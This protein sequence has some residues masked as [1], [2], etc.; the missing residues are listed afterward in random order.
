MMGFESYGFFVLKLVSI[1]VAI[2]MV[3]LGLMLISTRAKKVL[4]KGYLS[5]SSMDEAF[6]KQCQIVESQVF[7]KKALKQRAK[8]RKKKH[9][10]SQKNDKHKI[11]VLDFKGDIAASAVDN[12]R[13][14][15]DAVLQVA[16]AKQ[17]E[18][19]LRLESPGGTVPGYG[20]AASQLDRL[21]Q[22]NIR[23]TVAVDK[24][25]ASGGYMMACV[26]NQIIAAPFSIIGSIGVIF[27]L[28]NLYKWLDKKGIEFEQ[29][30]AGEFK[31]TLTVFGKNSKDARNKVQEEVDETHHLFKQFVSDHR[32]SVDIKQVATG[33]YWFAAQAFEMHLVDQLQTSDDYLLNKHKQTECELY[34]VQWKTHKSLK[35]KFSQAARLMIFGV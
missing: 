3:W 9:K 23:L 21:S 24:V 28:P 4:R 27:Q 14:E 16:D 5:V 7:Q 20:L 13:R 29:V 10:A 17:D 18:V 30:K 8:A 25:A 2:L 15:I 11:F 32:P 19:V 33:Q 31:R 26:A 1:I 35:S 6:T 22:A 12:L 34:Q